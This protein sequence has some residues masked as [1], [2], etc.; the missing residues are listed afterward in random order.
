VGNTVAAWGH[1]GA[2]PFGNVVVV[3]DANHALGQ[4]VFGGSLL[5][6]DLAHYNLH[7]INGDGP[8]LGRLMVAALQVPLPAALVQAQSFLKCFGPFTVI[9]RY[10][11][12]TTVFCIVAHGCLLSLLPAASR[13]DETGAP[14]ARDG[15]SEPRGAVWGLA[16][17]RPLY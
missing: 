16:T 1:M 11:R 7:Q 9:V 6:A 2:D 4:E 3:E 13:L 17:L 5:A 10:G 15:S 12:R 8:V 14:Q